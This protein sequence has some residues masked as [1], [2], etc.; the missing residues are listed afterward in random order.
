[1][2]GFGLNDYNIALIG[3]PNVGK[4]TLFNRLIG[5]KKAIV[6]TIPGTTRDR[7]N[8]EIDIN[9]EKIIV[10]DVGGFSEDQLDEFSD[11]I[12]EQIEFSLNNCD[13]IIMITD[14]NDG[15]APTDKKVAQIVRNSNKKSILVVN[16]I[17]NSNKEQFVNEF[18]ELGFNEIIGI[19]A[20]HNLN[21]DLLIDKILAELP[22]KSKNELNQISTQ[23][24][25][26]IVGRPNTGK[27]TLFN[28]LH[29]SKRSITSNIPGTTRDSIDYDI[30]VSNQSYNIV[31]TPGIRRRG[32]IDN[33]IEKVSVNKAIDYISDSDVSIL[34]IDTLE[35]ATN[36][37]AQIIKTVL[38]STDGIIV[39]INKSD[40]IKSRNLNHE[41]IEKKVREEF[42]FLK[43]AP[44]IFISGLKG[45][46]IT[47]L[48]NLCNQIY[49]KSKIIHD[50]NELNN[51]IMSKVAQNLPKN[52]PGQTLHIYGIKQHQ[53]YPNVFEFTVNNP[54]YVHFSYKRYIENVIREKFDYK[55]VIIKLFFRSRRKK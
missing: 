15:I 47:D 25:L 2:I 30:V 43:D 40:L 8:G 51:F 46:K 31:D 14:G 1:M 9:D 34:L 33:F 49:K 37:D 45:I 32:K 20:Y 48:I 12:R 6:S 17:D 18:Y 38:H 53:I 26:S 23:I 13:L 3:R 22:S 42:K 41:D 19:S 28:K 39:A 5:R 24:R 27:S 54:N 50:E 4:S 52:K 11:H 36:Q 21:I 7:I 35:P 16:K 29:G 55:G 10:T 44:L